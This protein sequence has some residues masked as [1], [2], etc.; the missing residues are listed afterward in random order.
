M[1]PRASFEVG[2]MGIAVL[3]LEVL[4]TPVAL[5]VGPDASGRHR[6]GSVPDVATPPKPAAPSYTMLHN[7]PH[8]RLAYVR[9][10]AL[11]WT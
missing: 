3:R 11:S 7:S 5:A 10:G 1:E 8:T 6:A 9:R 2:R 4:S